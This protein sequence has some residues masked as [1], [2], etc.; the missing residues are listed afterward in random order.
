MALVMVPVPEGT[1]LEGEI[2]VTQIQ[3]M[4]ATL[5]FP[6]AATPQPVRLPPTMQG[7]F[8]RTPP[9]HTLRDPSA[10][11]DLRSMK[12]LVARLPSNH[13]LRFAL[14]GEPDWLPSAEASM[15]LLEWTKYL[16][17]KER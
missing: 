9:E 14:Q 8:P 2:G 5:D 3:D 10:V 12:R 4:G 11:T 7:A 15:K 13:P 17:W 16:G 1:T 6:A